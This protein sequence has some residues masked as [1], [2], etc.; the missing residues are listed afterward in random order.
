MIFLQTINS[1]DYSYLDEQQKE[2]KLQTN[3]GVLRLLECV[4]QPSKML[5]E[6]K[7]KKEV[8][9]EDRRIIM[10]LPLS[11]LWI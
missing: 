10:L 5:Q 11:I 3:C 6:V 9:N 1:I 2:D 8:N 7:E 4:S